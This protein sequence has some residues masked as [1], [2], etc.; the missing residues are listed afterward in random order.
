MSNLESAHVVVVG[1]TMIDMV[2]YSK[3]IPGS[4]ETVIGDNF[5]TGFGGKGGPGGPGGPGGGKGGAGATQAPSK[6]QFD[7]PMSNISADS[8]LRFK[9]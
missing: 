9:R 1:S 5:I 7:I 4:G 6:T 8:P 3:K 2:T